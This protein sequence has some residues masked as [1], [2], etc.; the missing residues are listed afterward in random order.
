MH[1][2][3]SGTVG[4]LPGPPAIRSNTSHASKGFYYILFYSTYGAACYVFAHDWWRSQSRVLA[5]CQS[6]LC[7]SRTL[8]L[9][10]TRCGAGY[11]NGLP[12]PVGILYRYRTYPSAGSHE[13][14]PMVRP[15]IPHRVISPVTRAQ[16]P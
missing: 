4:I 11:P 3:Q 8:N 16:A 7:Y 1:S 9:T 13:P 10:H 6:V 5:N 2:R 14:L 12:Y 15:V